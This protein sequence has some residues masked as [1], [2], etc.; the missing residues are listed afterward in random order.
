MS[1]VIS[2]KLF[3]SAEE[4]E[5]W[6]YEREES[7]IVSIQPIISEGNFNFY[8]TKDQKDA[9]LDGEMK[10]SVFVTFWKEYDGGVNS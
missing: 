10:I 5:F 7:K 3:K 9:K 4:F 2:Y 6:Q 1:N 8:E